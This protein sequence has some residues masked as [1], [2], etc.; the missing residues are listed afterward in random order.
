MSA[1]SERLDDRPIGA[2]EAPDTPCRGRTDEQGPN[3]KENFPVPGGKRYPYNQE[4]FSRFILAE[5]DPRNETAHAAEQNHQDVR[6]Q[7]EAPRRMHSWIEPD[8]LAFL[9]GIG[10]T[11]KLVRLEGRCPIG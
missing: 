10:F 7:R 5:P 11:T 8:Q 3:P 6:K 4:L 9:V 1:P 2:A